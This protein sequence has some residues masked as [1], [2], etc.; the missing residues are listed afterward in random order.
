MWN[1]IDPRIREHIVDV[2]QSETEKKKLE[3]LRIKDLHAKHYLY[4]AIDRVNFKQILDRKTTK[5]VWD[6]MQKRFA[7][8][9]Q[10]KKSMLQKLRRDF[11]VSR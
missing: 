2:A 4:Q 10:V 11:E 5:A 3:E 9:D 7:G 8:N 6:S 1:L